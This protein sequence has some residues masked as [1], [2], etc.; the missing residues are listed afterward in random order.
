MCIRD[1]DTVRALCHDLRQPLAVIRLLA[2]T[3]GGDVQH[4]LDGILE[5]AQWLSDV[6]EGV[7]GGAA[8]DSPRTLDVVELVAHCV[9]RARPT[10]DYQVPLREYP[11]EFDIAWSPERTLNGNQVGED[12]VLV[13]S[14]A[15]I[16]GVRD[17]GNRLRRTS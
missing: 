15:P 5:E 8:D 11:D 10:A 17:A 9:H 3:R 16:R 12:A 7:I 2:G 4:R 6:V 14:E 13:E 1:R